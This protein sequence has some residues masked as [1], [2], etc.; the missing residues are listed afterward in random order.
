MSE[1]VEVRRTGELRFDR[2]SDYAFDLISPEGN[3][4]IAWRHPSIHH[5]DGHQVEVV[6]RMLPERPKAH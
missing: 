3:V 5:M 2:Y 6:I 4:G 1:G